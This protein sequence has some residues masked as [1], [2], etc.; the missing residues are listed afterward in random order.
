MKC[1]LLAIAL[2][3]SCSAL[4]GCAIPANPSQTMQFLNDPA[5]LS[6]C[7][8]TGNTEFTPAGSVIPR[9]MKMTQAECKDYITAKEKEKADAEKK[10][11]MNKHFKES[12]AKQAQYNKDHAKQYSADDAKARSLCS[13]SMNAI[14]RRYDLGK[15][16]LVTAHKTGTP[17]TMCVVRYAVPNVYGQ[18]IIHQ[19]AYMINPNGQYELE[20]AL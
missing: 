7:A 16:T 17:A 9:Y 2:I 1:S 20:T 14:G 12:Q 5:K 6:N 8:N 11:E 10:A 13:S 4:T 19:V 3:A 15:A 18:N